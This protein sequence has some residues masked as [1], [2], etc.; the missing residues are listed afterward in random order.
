L[1]GFMG[2]YMILGILFLFI[3]AREI[4]RGPDPVRRG[5][6]IGSQVAVVEGGTR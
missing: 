1:L 2:M 4:A 5:A 6:A 3:V